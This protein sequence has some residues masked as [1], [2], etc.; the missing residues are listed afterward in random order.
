MSVVPVSADN[1]DHQTI[2]ISGAGNSSSVTTRTTTPLNPSCVILVTRISTTTYT[3]LISTNSPGHSVF[4]GVANTCVS[5]N[6]P[7]PGLAVTTLSDV[8]V[9][10]GSGSPTCPAGF[11]RTG[12]LVLQSAFST[13]GLA[14]DPTGANSETQITV[15]SGSGQLQGITGRGV[16]VVHATTTTSFSTYW[17]E[18]T[19][20]D[21]GE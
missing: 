4:N 8:T 7:G 3:G 11:S 20:A 14:S 19:F 12:N 21:S 10:C 18:L 2:T 1:G 9:S 6:P 15:L 17:I 13:T 5:P 16:S